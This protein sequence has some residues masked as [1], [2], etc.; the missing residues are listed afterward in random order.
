MAQA[1][2]RDLVTLFTKALRKLGEAGEVEEA[3]MLAAQAWWGLQ[4]TDPRAAERVNGTMHYLARLPAG[5]GR[6]ES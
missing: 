2:D 5:S 3:S 1:P 6:L 4:K